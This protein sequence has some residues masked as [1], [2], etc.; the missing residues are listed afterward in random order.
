[1]NMPPARKTPKHFEHAQSGK[2][3]ARAGGTAAALCSR[4]ADRRGQALP[5]FA[6]LLPIIAVVLFGIIEFG[7]A[8]NSESDETHLANEVARYAIVNENPGGSE[9]L[10]EWAKRQGDNNFLKSGAKICISFPEGSEVGKPV[11]V[12]A[13]STIK[14]VP[15]VNLSVATSTIRGTAYMRMESP[16]SAYKAGCSS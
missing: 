6:L 12:E 9:A 5:E 16:P 3:P 8:L 15:A 10:Q 7:L 13:T 14:W 4:L 2:A 1:M 11:K